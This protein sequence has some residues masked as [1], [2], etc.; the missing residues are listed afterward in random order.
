MNFDV[1]KIAFVIFIL[2]T[3]GVTGYTKVLEMQAEEHC[4]PIAG[5]TWSV[6]SVGEVIVERAVPHHS[7]GTI[8]DYTDGE[9]HLSAG[10]ESFCLNSEIVLLSEDDEGFVIRIDL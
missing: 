3:A 5:Q 2:L 4:S 6:L 7:F 8:I 1:T 9:T 10:I